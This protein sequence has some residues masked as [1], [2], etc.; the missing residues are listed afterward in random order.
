[1]P[2]N[3]AEA[4]IPLSNIEDQAL[5]VQKAQRNLTDRE[6]L[7]A[8][9]YNKQEAKELAQLIDNQKNSCSKIEPKLTQLRTRR[10]KLKQ[11][12]KSVKAAIDHH[13]SNL[14]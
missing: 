5:K 1:M 14:T 10:A 9:N 8:K 7:M 2:T 12:L 13:E 3:L 6:A 11:E 4:L